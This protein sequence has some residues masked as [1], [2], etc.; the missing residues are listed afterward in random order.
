[1]YPLDQDVIDNYK[2]LK[3]ERGLT[4]EQ[5]ASHVPSDRNT[6]AWLRSQVE[7]DRVKSRGRRPTDDA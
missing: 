1:M 7:P 6:A 3:V 4:W 5:L 2:A